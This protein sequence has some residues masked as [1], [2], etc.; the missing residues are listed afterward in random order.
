MT[1][2]S[3]TDGTKEHSRRSMW[4]NRDGVLLRK[5]SPMQ[6]GGSDVGNEQEIVQA[7]KPV[8]DGTDSPGE[9]GPAPITMIVTLVQNR[10]GT[11]VEILIEPGD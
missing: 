3:L 9:E 5:S 11:S 1:D 7:S 10:A 8:N 6:L 4:A 2:K